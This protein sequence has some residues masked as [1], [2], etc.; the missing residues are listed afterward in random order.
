MT[1]TL[2][3]SVCK[4]EAENRTHQVRE[5]LHGTRDSFQYMECSKCGHLGLTSIPQNLA[6]YYKADYYSLKGQGFFKSKLKA[7]RSADAFGKKSRLSTFLAKKFGYPPIVTWLKQANTAPDARI[8][9]IGCG[10]GIALRDLASCNFKVLHGIDPFLAKDFHFGPVFLQKKSL[11]AVQGLYDLIILNHS[12]EHMPNQIDVFKQLD[13]ILAPNGVILIRIPLLGNAWKKF[14]NACYG[15]DAPRHLSLHT[16]KSFYYLLD[17]T[18]FKVFQTVFDG[19]EHFYLASIQYQKDI[20][21]TA[22]TSY[23]VNPARSI[24]SKADFTAARAEAQLANE[25]G[26]GD[27]ASFYLRRKV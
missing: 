7:M 14:G 13:K 25:S 12:L 8:L 18:P 2:R 5:M 26:D 3:C 10:M 19:D 11:N 6:T 21:F 22:E 17:Q 24:F 9:D 1:M 16:I 15:I 20:P 23:L 4:N 27:Q